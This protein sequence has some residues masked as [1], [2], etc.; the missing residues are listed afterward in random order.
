MRPGKGSQAGAV[1]LK[2]SSIDG[3]I[4]E[5]AA[6]AARALTEKEGGAN[7]T[8]DLKIENRVWPLRTASPPILPH[9]PPLTYTARA[10]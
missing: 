1:C 6:R 9:P 8:A 2:A 7:L 3:L 4:S 5:A 10:S